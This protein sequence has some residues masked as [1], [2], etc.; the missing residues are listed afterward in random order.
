MVGSTTKGGHGH[1]THQRKSSSYLARAASGSQGAGCASLRARNDPGDRSGRRCGR[2]Q[3]RQLRQGVVAGG[4]RFDRA[5][6]VEGGRP[7]H[8]PGADRSEGQ[9]LL[10]GP[11]HPAGSQERGDYREIRRAQ[12]HAGHECQ[13]QPRYRPDPGPRAQVHG[14][15][16][17]GDD[18]VGNQSPARSTI[19]GR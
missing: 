10:Q 2:L 18:P 12:R 1:E 6:A 15:M 16:H 4:A 19:P 3:P 9:R 11:V 8:Q 7:E 5:H 13:R 17:V 14:H